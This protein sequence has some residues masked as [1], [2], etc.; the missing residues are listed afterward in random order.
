MRNRIL[1]VAIVLLVS[2]SAL[3]QS[4]KK[5]STSSARAKQVAWG[6]YLTLVGGCNDC[7]T[8]KIKPGSMEPDVTR[9]LSGRPPSTPAP[10]KPATMGEISVS[11]DLTAWYGPWG[12]SYTSN[13]TPHPTT[14][15]GTRYNETSFIKT[16]RT[17]T[18]PEGEPLLPP[19]PWENFG[20]MSDG[21]L[22]A[23]W[24]Y[25]K[26]IKPVDNYVR[27]AAPQ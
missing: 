9:L 11:G 2:V 12:V 4:K 21:D 6:K 22:K 23:I 20:K 27:T 13:L 17:G 18:K 8:P 16:M 26:S 24:A 25:L 3:G 15:I 19:M 14:G 7:H 5:S 1:V 10:N